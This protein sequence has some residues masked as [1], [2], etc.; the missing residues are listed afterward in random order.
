MFDVKKPLPFADATF[1]T[2]YS[3][4]LLNMSFSMVE[5]QFIFSEIKQVLKPRGHFFSVRNE[6]DN[7]Y[8]KGIEIQDGVYDNDGFQIRFY[9]KYDI[10]FLT[11]ED[12]EIL[13]IKEEHE[14]PVTLYAVHTRKVR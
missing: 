3:P 5:L 2:V 9:T 8:K 14:E 6:N 13:S 1:D 12:F 7:F 10:V 4:M 11:K